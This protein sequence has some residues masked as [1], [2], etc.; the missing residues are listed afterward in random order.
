MIDFDEGD[1]HTGHVQIYHL[2]QW[3]YICDTN[4]DN[5][6]GAVVCSQLGFE[7]FQRITL[8]SYHNNTSGMYW[9]ENVNCHDAD[10]SFAECGVTF[11]NSLDCYGNIAGVRCVNLGKHTNSLMHT[12]L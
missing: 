11:D 2:D 6:D 9:T 4:W 5:T 7:G 8:Q 3:G 1:F 12:L 10:K